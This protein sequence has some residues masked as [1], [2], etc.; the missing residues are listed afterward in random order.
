MNPN[1][2]IFIVIISITCLAYGL[3]SLKKFN[4]ECEVLSEKEI[5]FR[6]DTKQDIY[7]II[8]IGFVGFVGSMIIYITRF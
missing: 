8:I 3:Y 1:Y 6:G 7:G 4:K 2:L 5:F